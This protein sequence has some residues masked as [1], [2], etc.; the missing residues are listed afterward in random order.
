MGASG[1][2]GRGSPGQ[3]HIPPARLAC[4]RYVRARQ[5][6][7]KTKAATNAPCEEKREGGRSVRKESRVQNTCA[8]R[9]SPVVSA[10]VQPRMPTHDPARQ[11]RARETAMSTLR[12]GGAVWTRREKGGGGGG[13]GP[14]VQP[15][16]GGG[17][18]PGRAAP[19]W[20][21]LPTPS[22]RMHPRTH[23]VGPPKWEGRCGGVW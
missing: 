6:R 20:R 5:A 19:Y 11:L 2:R 16:R 23:A 17:P 3:R 13:V 10:L 8:R 22:Q 18:G 9:R 1:R 21:G 12:G 4:P 15:L 14:S 7:T